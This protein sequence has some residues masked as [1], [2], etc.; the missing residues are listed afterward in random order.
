PGS[1][2][3]DRIGSRGEGLF[4]EYAKEFVAT[5]AVE[6]VSGANFLLEPPRERMKDPIAG[7]MTVVIVVRLEMV[8]VEHGNAVAVLVAG[9]ARFQQ[10]EILFEGPPVTQPGERVLADEGRQLV[11]RAPQLVSGCLRVAGPRG[12]YLRFGEEV[13]EDRHFGS[14]LVR[15]DRGKHEVDRAL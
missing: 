9:H 5:E 3:L 4:G 14:K 1:H 12:K 2:A 15:S 11:V 13:R 6:R 10:V 7:G 8:D